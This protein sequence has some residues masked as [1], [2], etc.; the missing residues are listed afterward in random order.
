MPLNNLPYFK[1]SICFGAKNIQSLSSSRAA[2]VFRGHR[3]HSD[4]VWLGLE[5][6]GRNKL[7]NNEIWPLRIQN[8]CK[9]K[10]IR[11]N[12]KILIFC[13]VKL[14]PTDSTSSQTILIWC[15]CNFTS[16]GQKIESALVDPRYL[17]TLDSLSRW[18]KSSIIKFEKN[19][20]KKK[21]RG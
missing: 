11:E 13:G 5:S 3:Q 12:S 2:E 19:I 6:A 7:P 15:G 4:T 18:I 1:L 17:S 8:L 14:V 16:M 9:A 20:F 10:G 21:I